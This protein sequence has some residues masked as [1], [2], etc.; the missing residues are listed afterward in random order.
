MPKADEAKRT[1]FRQKIE[2]YEV[3]KK[4]IIYIDESGFEELPRVMERLALSGEDSLCHRI[5]YN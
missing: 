1:L 5:R 2:A 3:H 4:P